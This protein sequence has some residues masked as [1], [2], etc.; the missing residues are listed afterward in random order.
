MIATVPGGPD[1]LT[2]RAITPPAPGPGEIMIRQTAIGLNY[3]DVYFRQGL[4]PWPQGD[5]LI[6]GS[7]GAGVVEAL[8]AGVTGLTLGQRVAYAVTNGAYATHRLIPAA[9]AVA[10][11]DDIADEV[12][13]AVM[14]KGLTVHYLI[15]HSHAVTAGDTVLFHAAA[16]GVGLLAGQWLAEKGVRAIGTAGGPQKCALA[17]AHGYD[18]VID[19]RAEDVVGRVMDLTGGAGVAAA[20]D[21]VGADTILGSVA[22]LARFGTLVSFGQSSGA[23]EALRVSHLA[24]ASL[25]LTRPSLFHHSASPGWL[26]RAAGDLFGV[27]RSGAVQVCIGA[28]WPL[29]QVAQA[30][31]ALEARAT[32]GSTVLIP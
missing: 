31:G 16:G 10:L 12:A 28:H 21:S 29:D 25:R 8:G 15:N 3:I 7:E 32:T 14:L 26:A 20:Y 23:P 11:P 9:Q 17:R 13:A 19:S 6:L 24:R 18:A 2:R 4:Y 5:G 1:V 30:H 27:I 22:V